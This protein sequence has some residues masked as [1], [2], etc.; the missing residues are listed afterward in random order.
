MTSEDIPRG[1]YVSL[2]GHPI[3]RVTKISYPAS[4]PLGPPSMGAK[5]SGVLVEAEFIHQP[6]MG[7]CY[8]F[9]AVW[10]VLKP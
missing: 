4:H 9:A 1:V 2:R 6:R 8:F 3:Y 7:E 10:L 5:G